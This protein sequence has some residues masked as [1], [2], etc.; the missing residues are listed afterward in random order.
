MQAATEVRRAELKNGDV[1]EGEWLRGRRHGTG[2][3]RWRFGGSYEGEWQASYQHG[4]GVRSYRNGDVHDGEWDLDQRCGQGVMHYHNGE[5]YDGEWLDEKR[6]GAFGQMTYASGDTYSGEWLDDQPHGEGVM[7]YAKR[8]Q[9]SDDQIEDQIHGRVEDLLQAQQ[10]AREELIER[11]VAALLPPEPDEKEKEKLEKEKAQAKQDAKRKGKAEEA[12]GMDADEEAEEEGDPEENLR[13]MLEAKTLV[14]LN[15]LGRT[16]EAGPIAEA[17]LAQIPDR[18]EIVGLLATVSLLE[19]PSENLV[20]ALGTL[21]HPRAGQPARQ[22]LLQVQVEADALFQSRLHPLQQAR[23]STFA[24]DVEAAVEAAQAKANVVNQYEGGWAHGQREGLGRLI[25]TDGSSWA[26]EWAADEKHG[27]GTL[28]RMDESVEVE[29]R[30][31]KGRLTD[32]AAQYQYQDYPHYVKI[33]EEAVEKAV[34]EGKKALA[35]IEKERKKLKKAE[36]A[37]KKEQKARAKADKQAAAFEEMDDKERKEAEEAWVDPRPSMKTPEEWEEI[38]A[39]LQGYVTGA[40]A[41]A[42]DA[43][44]LIVVKEEELAAQIA[45]HGPRREQ[46]QTT[47]DKGHLDKKLP[48]PLAAHFPLD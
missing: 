46:W 1:Y 24:M 16:E 21:E 30:W 19:S 36:A 45:D 48:F 39:E 5:V 8:V 33:Y 32:P 20:D 13:A 10:D 22:T 41:K 35:S 11:L 44:Q 15:E 25:N 4:R 28:F 34:H 18:T 42:E 43:K 7:V 26:G 37:H 12:E 9:V 47:F 27:L 38:F 29:G 31:E 40:E 3:Y 14:E 23:H 17:S 6:H 2:V